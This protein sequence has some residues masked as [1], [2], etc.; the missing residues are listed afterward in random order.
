MIRFA[1]AVNGPVYVRMGRHKLPVITKEN[2]D[3][4]FDANYNYEY[5][6]TELIRSGAGVTVICSGPIVHEA[7]TAREKHG[8]TAEIVM[9]SSPKKF[10]ETLIQS[11]LKNQHVIVVEDHNPHTGYGAGVAKFLLERG[12]TPKSFTTMG[13]TE[14][15]LSG[16]PHELYK[17]AGISAEDIARKVVEI[18]H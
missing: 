5:G 16:K 11:V 13:V 10:D 1:A 3:I 18:R 12:L 8:M 14:Y 15:Q 17:S 4:F 9:V 7:L 6:K 2:G